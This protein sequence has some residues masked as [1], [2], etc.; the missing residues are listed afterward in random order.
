M[1]PFARIAIPLFALILGC[2]AVY[3]AAGFPPEARRKTAPVGIGERA[4]KV[5]A[6]A[7]PFT[8][9]STDGDQVSLAAV[10]AEKPVVLVFYRGHW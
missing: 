8:L 1:R 3:K 6:E 5:G 9:E 2:G 10:T 7:P 4:I